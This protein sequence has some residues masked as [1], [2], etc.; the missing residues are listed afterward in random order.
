MRSFGEVRQGDISHAQ[1]L[2]VQ[3][4]PV[5]HLE[6]HQRHR[7]DVSH[8]QVSLSVFLS[9]LAVVNKCLALP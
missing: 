3:I 5:R 8:Q 7:P 9:A 2:R 4:L 6:L 1:L